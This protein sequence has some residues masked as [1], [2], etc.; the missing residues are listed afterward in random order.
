MDPNATDARVRAAL[1]DATCR[2]GPPHPQ[3]DGRREVAA[4]IVDLAVRGYVDVAEI[5][6]AA[7]WTLTRTQQGWVGMRP[8]EAE[9]LGQVF[10]GSGQV[11]V[12][13][14]RHRLS[15]GSC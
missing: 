11:R 4:T 5:G 7:D 10:V 3:A 9:L 12:S 2:A 15:Q 14:L 1:P 13:E 6:D 8:Y